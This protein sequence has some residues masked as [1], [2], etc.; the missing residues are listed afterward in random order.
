[1]HPRDLSSLRAHAGRRVA[2]AQRLAYH[3]DG[4]RFPDL[5]AKRRR[6]GSLVI[7]AQIGGP[8][9]LLAL[10]WWVAPWYLAILL[11]MAAGLAGVV[12]G[13]RLVE[14]RAVA[15]F[16]EHKRALV[17]RELVEAGLTERALAALLELP[18]ALLVVDP[19]ASSSPA[20]ELIGRAT[21]AFG[22]LVSGASSASLPAWVRG[23]ADVLGPAERIIVEVLR[24][25]ARAHATAT[26]A[27]APV[28]SRLTRSVEALEA[29][30]GPLEAVSGGG[31][32]E[33][34]LRAQVSELKLAA[35]AWSSADVRE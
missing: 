11:S 22:E 26:P 2:D 29:A 17:H 32:S 20:A 5:E 15:A 24:G 33:E 30:T 13:D 25:A 4:A 6:L 31:S 23:Q 21:T 1:M 16:E 9:V 12:V 14:Q 28:W 8:F 34:E 7:A 10:L 3:T 35:E 19:A 27:D 18:A